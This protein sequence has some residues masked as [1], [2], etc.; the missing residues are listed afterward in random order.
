MGRLI[1][2]FITLSVFS[3]ALLPLATSRKSRPWSP[4]DVARWCAQTPHPEPCKYYLTHTHHRFPRPKHKSQFRALLVQ[5]AFDEAQLMQ[6]QAHSYARGCVTKKQKAVFSDCLKLYDNTI[7]QLNQTLYGIRKTKQ[8][9]RHR[10]SVL[11]AQTW[12]SAALTNIQTCRNGAA[13]LNIT[14]SDFIADSGIS[15][16]CHNVTK[17]ISN[18][19]AGVV[20]AGEEAVGGGG[21][22]DKGESGGGSGRDGAF[23][24]GIDGL[25]F[26]A[27]DITF[28]NTAGPRKGQAV[29]LR[30][31]SDLSVFYRC[32]IVG[33][34]DTLMAHAQRQ[35]YKQCYIY[36][37][38]DMIF[39]NAAV[40]FQNCMIYAR[41]PLPGQANMITAQGRGDPFQN[42]GISIHN[43]QIRAA[44]DLKPVMNQ[45]ATYLGR[46][47]QQYSRVVVMKTYIENLV[48]PLGW[49]PWGN[50]NFALNTL[51]FGEYRNLGPGSS[52]NNRVKWPGFHI[53][54]SPTEA[55]SFTVNSLLAGR[56]W[57]PSTEICR[58]GTEEQNEWYFFSHKDK[59]YP[60][61]TRTNRAT[62]AGFWKATGRDKAIYSKHDLIG[63]R[64]TLV[65]YKGRAPNGQKSDWIMHEY[66]LETDENGTPQAKL[67]LHHLPLIPHQLP[68]RHHL[69]QQLPLLDH[70]TPKLLQSSVS[71]SINP[72]NNPMTPFGL[73]VMNHVMEGATQDQ[74]NFQAMYGSS[75]QEQ[76][77]EDDQVTDWRVLDKFVAS[78]LSQE[79]V[80][81]NKD[82]NNNYSSND[83]GTS[84]NSN[85]FQTMENVV[86]SNVQFRSSSSQLEKQEMVPENASTSTSS[87]PIDLWK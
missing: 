41:R 37:T 42:T 25:H 8:P 76:V 1:S 66:R 47:W 20:E 49:S 9:K 74:Q 75:G 56:T 68:T 51:Y 34:Q 58:I 7:F 21:D 52:I 14:D 82:H 73:D 62:A 57:L 11:D 45:F 70:Q 48:S 3:C 60:T 40:V 85:I 54:T 83:A 4:N 80:V 43:S 30:S 44:P 35:F 31:A 13:D 32:A 79:D 24:D 26:I 50:S 61:G 29:A 36:G 19:L 46:P 71:A 28:E 64:K 17:M 5:L 10:C 15:S 27:R 39:G 78:Q 69:F 53:I 18:T 12:L 23:Q 6:A 38:V 16:A 2:L 63:M 72:N 65:F 67:D 84:S 59:K 33:Y 86:G 77:V 87:C 55:S 22:G 81:A